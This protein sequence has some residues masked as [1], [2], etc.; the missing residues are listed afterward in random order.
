M[1]RSARAS[2]AGDELACGIDVVDIDA[3]SKVVTLRGE[4]F[5]CRVFTDAELGECK[6]DPARLAARFA[7]KEAVAK[8]MGTGISE[9]RMRDVEV[10]LDERGRPF[11]RLAGAARA[12]ADELGLRSWSVS[13]SH[14]ARVATA[15]VVAAAGP[16]SGHL[17]PG[18]GMKEAV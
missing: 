13:I 5:L 17:V 7:A 18:S 2:S 16:S 9:T 1:A 4:T 10:C 3:F 14:S 8:A 12:R 15:M 6:G 11:L